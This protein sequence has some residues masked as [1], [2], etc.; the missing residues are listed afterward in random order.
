DKPF[1]L[2]EAEGQPHGPPHAA[3]LA[4]D[5]SDLGR[6]LRPGGSGGRTG[7]ASLVREVQFRAAA[8]GVLHVGSRLARYDEGRTH[9][10]DQARVAR[11]P[12]NPDPPTAAVIIEGQTVERLEPR[13]GGGGGRPAGGT[14]RGAR[15]TRG[16]AA[17]SLAAAAAPPFRGGANGQ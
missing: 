16:G 14:F 8:G 4:A 5:E 6:L 10:V 12:G 13:G 9:G 2:R 1:H 17:M 7:A 15:G 3:T 11:L